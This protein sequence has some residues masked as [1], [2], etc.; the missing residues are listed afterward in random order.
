MELGISTFGELQPDG[1]A[2]KA[3]NAQKRVQELL[4]E[5]KLADDVPQYQIPCA[6]GN[7]CDIA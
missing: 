7:G 6:I 1:T 5:V 2:G 3:I 4:E